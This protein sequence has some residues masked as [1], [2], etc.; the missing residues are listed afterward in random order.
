MKKAN[1]T[2]TGLRSAVFFEKKKLHRL[3]LERNFFDDLE[4]GPTCVWFTAVQGGN[5]AVVLTME[6]GKI[7]A[8]SKYFHYV[9]PPQNS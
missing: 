8:D 6:Q 3:F 5:Y 7:H 1:R 4:C 9:F 2:K